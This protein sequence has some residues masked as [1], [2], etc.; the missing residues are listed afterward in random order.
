M[1]F[2]E[3]Q[4]L[5]KKYGTI[6]YTGNRSADLELMEEEI[7]ELERLGLI[8]KDIYRDS[9]LLIKKEQRLAGGND[10]H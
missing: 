1:T 10:K 7:K 5:L 2:F 6:I 3:L 9:L 8:E 4:Q